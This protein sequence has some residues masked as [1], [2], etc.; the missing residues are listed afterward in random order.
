MFRK[1]KICVMSPIKQIHETLSRL[2]TGSKRSKWID[3]VVDNRSICRSMGFM[4]PVLITVVVLFGKSQF[5]YLIRRASMDEWHNVQ[6][7]QNR[8]QISHDEFYKRPQSEISLMEYFN[9]D[10]TL[11]QSDHIKLQR[12]WSCVGAEEDMSPSQNIFD[13]RRQKLVFLHIARSAG[14]TIRAL[15][16]AYANF[17]TAGIVTISQ[18]IDLGIEFLGED[19]V[20]SNGKGSHAAGAEC[21]LSSAVP[22]GRNVSV[23]NVSYPQVSTAMLKLWDIDILAGALP[24]GCLDQHFAD[25]QY[26]AFFRDPLSKLVS[27]LIPRIEKVYGTEVSLESA[28]DLISAF[29]EKRMNGTH[30]N[31]R[32]QEKYSSYILTPEQ[33]AFVEREGIEWTPERRVN[34]TLKNLY[35]KRIMVGIVDD[36]AASMQLLKFLIDGSNRV[37]SLFQF[38][39]SDDEIAKVPGHLLTRNFTKA[40]V[41]GIKQDQTLLSK[42]QEY[43]KYEQQIY[44]HALSIHTRQFGMVQKELMGSM[45]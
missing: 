27:E 35:S 26:V 37:D 19:D 22:R 20:W 38:F 43:V 12:M 6:V 17:C 36:M 8:S 44:D 4:L 7:T 13:D 33:K 41:D 29:V 11:I 45:S 34:L 21:R 23:V 42:L 14:S 28:Q 5:T 2:K 1:N 3:Q 39:L 31:L 16:R 25:V 15:L 32:Y 10:Q 40:V 9:F 24:L 18:C 30:A